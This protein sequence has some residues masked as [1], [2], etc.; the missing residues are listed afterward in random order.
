[1]L[2]GCR[3]SEILTLRWGDV[4]IESNELE[5]RDAKTG[6][7]T[8]PLSPSAVSLLAG[9]PRTP[10]DPWVIPGRKPNTPMRDLRDAWETIRSRAG[11]HDVRLHDLR[12]SFASRA[13]ALGESLPMIGKLLGHSQIETTARYAHLA[14]DSVRESAARVSESIAADLLGEDWNPHPASSGDGLRRPVME[15]P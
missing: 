9:L 8:V 15:A 4:A 10:G 1:M 2:T 3:R 13:L 11:L 14:R 6:A 12:H 7:R 5:L